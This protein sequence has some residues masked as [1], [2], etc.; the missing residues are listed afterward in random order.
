MSDDLAIGL[1]LVLAAAWLF[2][3]IWWGGLAVQVAKAVRS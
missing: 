1:V 2:A 3:R